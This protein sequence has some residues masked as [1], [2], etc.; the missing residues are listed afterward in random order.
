VAREV[1]E[2]AGPMDGGVFLVVCFGEI[3]LHTAFGR[4]G[5]VLYCII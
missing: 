2:F 1:G 3:V 4:E 5:F